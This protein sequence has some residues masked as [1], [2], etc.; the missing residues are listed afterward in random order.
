LPFVKNIIL[1]TYNIGSANDGGGGDGD[2]TVF[3]LLF[4]VVSMMISYII[5]QPGRRKD[6]LNDVKSIPL[7]PCNDIDT[8][9]MHT[10]EIIISYHSKKSLELN[11]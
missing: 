5:M 1:G 10:N 2:T 4:F 11:N 7:F 9:K 6:I 8:E 3:D